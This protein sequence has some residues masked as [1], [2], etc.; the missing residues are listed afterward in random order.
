VVYEADVSGR[1]D[2][3]EYTQAIDDYMTAEVLPYVE[4][5]WADHGRTKIGYE[6]PVTRYFYRY[7]PPRPLNEIDA[8]IKQLESEIQNLLREVTE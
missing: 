7:V 2:T 5:A 6:I 3:T 8:E 4:D 1:L